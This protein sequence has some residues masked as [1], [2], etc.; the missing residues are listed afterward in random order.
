M[1]TSSLTAPLAS[2]LRPYCHIPRLLKL[3]K[4][5]LLELQH[6]CYTVAMTY[7]PYKNSTWHVRKWHRKFMWS[8]VFLGEYKG[9]ELKQ[10]AF[11]TARTSIGSQLSRCRW[12]QLFL[13]QLMNSRYIHFFL[14]FVSSRTLLAWASNR[15]VNILFVRLKK[16]FYLI[17]NWGNASYFFRRIAVCLHS[18]FYCSFVWVKP[19][20]SWKYHTAAVALRSKGP[21]SVIWSGASMVRAAKAGVI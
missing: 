13:F 2:S 21:R 7:C 3:S 5:T 10:E 19:I 17:E 12:R 14:T 9:G 1:R 18:I 20:Y 6:C 16:T 15:D 11:M 8:H 4:I